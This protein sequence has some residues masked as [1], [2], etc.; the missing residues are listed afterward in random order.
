MQYEFGDLVRFLSFFTDADSQPI[1][2]DCVARAIMV[3][4]FPMRGV[5]ERLRATHLE[6]CADDVVQVVRQKLNITPEVVASMESSWC[7]K[8]A[9]VEETREELDDV[10]TGLNALVAEMERLRRAR[11][12]L[13]RKLSEAGP[14]V[15]KLADEVA[16]GR[17]ILA[18]PLRELVGGVLAQNS[19]KRKAEEAMSETRKRLW[20]SFGQDEVTAA[21]NLVKF[22]AAQQATVGGP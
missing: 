10:V 22:S 21:Q 4:T 1:V 20:H 19:R 17:R 14:M 5:S 6:G 7:S 3:A 2:S 8:V 16:E 13:E 18:T 9:D 15:A 12:L 11:M